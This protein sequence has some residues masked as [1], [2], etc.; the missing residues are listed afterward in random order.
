VRSLFT[1]WNDALATGDSRIVAGRYAN[2]ATLLPTVS[3]T[4]CCIYA[5][6]HF[7][8]TQRRQGETKYSSCF[9]ISLCLDASPHLTSFLLHIN[10]IGLGYPPH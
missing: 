3:R 6:R 2:G 5:G 4:G 9:P 7:L 8:P 10:G 1:L